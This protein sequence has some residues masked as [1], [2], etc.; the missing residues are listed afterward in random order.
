MGLCGNRAGEAY[1]HVKKGVPHHHGVVPR[2][3]PSAVLLGNTLFDVAA[4]PLA[5]TFGVKKK[6]LITPNDSKRLNLVGLNVK[7]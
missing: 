7:I 1:S 3:D 2:G 6:N 4:Q 5:Y